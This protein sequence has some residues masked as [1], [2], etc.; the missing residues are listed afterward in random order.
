MIRLTGNR[1]SG[2]MKDLDVPES[3]IFTIGN[4]EDALAVITNSIDSKGEIELVIC[5]LNI[6]RG[7][8]R[9]DFMKTVKEMPNAPFIVICSKHKVTK[10]IKEL[11]D[12]VI[13]KSG[14]MKRH[15]SEVLQAFY[16]RTQKE[17]IPKPQK[18]FYRRS[19]SH[20]EHRLSHR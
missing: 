9:I 15:L 17:T 10:E 3:K 6:Q 7:D 13:S 19:H 16:D 1:V 18:E 4:S 20:M 14:N 5:D 8:E 2:A 11:A 12:K